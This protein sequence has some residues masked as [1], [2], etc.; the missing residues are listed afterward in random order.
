MSS[1]A[2]FKLSNQQGPTLERQGL[3]LNVI[4][5]PGRQGSLGGG[6]QIHVYVWLGPFADHLKLPQHCW[7]AKPEHKTFKNKVMFQIGI[8]RHLS[9]DFPLLSL[10]LPVT[11][12]AAHSPS[13]EKGG[14][15]PRASVPGTPGVAAAPLQT[16]L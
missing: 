16:Y 12:Y 3:L 5:Q 1:T 7:L 9:G 11:S 6:E 10:R 14:E 8:F 13:I 4:W 2:I 15:R